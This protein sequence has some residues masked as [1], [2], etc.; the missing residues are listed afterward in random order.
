MTEDILRDVVAA[1]SSKEV[2]DS[3]QKK[4]ASSSKART[5]Q[6]RVE[7][8][9]AKKQ[10]LSAADFF[11]KITGLATEL[12]AADAAL[13]DEEVLAYLLAG[14]PAALIPSSLP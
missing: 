13:R 11:H 3:L 14:L 7:L 2:W 12:A 6:I 1:T 9:T 5:M 4:F 8:A 10:D